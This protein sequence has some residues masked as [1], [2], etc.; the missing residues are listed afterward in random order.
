MT[1]MGES[2]REPSEEERKEVETAARLLSIA[3]V[4]MAL[5]TPESDEM[6]AALERFDQIIGELGLRDQVVVL[7]D[8]IAR[9]KQQRQR[10]GLSQTIAGALAGYTKG[11]ITNL[12]NGRYVSVAATERLRGLLYD[13]S[14][15][16]L[17]EELNRDV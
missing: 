9:F 16:K 8:P 10:L 12:E 14:L 1:G 17:A 7:S 6:N 2:N 13:G 5:S 4:Q 15:E 3:A 11:H